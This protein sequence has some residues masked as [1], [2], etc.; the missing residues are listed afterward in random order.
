MPND[1]RVLLLAVCAGLAACSPGPEARGTAVQV[2]TSAQVADVRVVP[3]ER[4]QT[5]LGWEAVAA[6]GAIECARELPQYWQEMIHRLVVDVG[7]NRLRI[8]LPTGVEG[9]NDGFDDF[10]AKRIDHA[11]WRARRYGGVNDNDDPTVLDPSGFTWRDF[12]VAMDTV[13]MPMKRALEGRGDRLYTVLT[14]IDF[15][16]TGFDHR[17]NPPEYAELVVAGLRHLREK[18]AHLPDA[19]EVIL[20]PNNSDWSA[21]Q[22][23]GAIK[24]LGQRLASEG[25]PLP[26][27]AP[28]HSNLTGSLRMFDA[29]MQDTGVRRYV[30]DFSYHRYGPHAPGDPRAIGDRARRFGVRTAMLEHIRGDHRELVED[31]T[32]AGASAWE[33]F[34]A[35][36]CQKDGGGEYVVA[37]VTQPPGRMVRLGARTRY[38]QQYFRDVRVGAVRI[39]ASASRRELRP[40][41]FQ[42]SVGRVVVV[43][44][45]GGATTLE[46]DGLP[47]GTYSFSY[48]TERTLR[49]T[50]SVRISS[51]RAQVRM[52]AAGVFTLAG[53]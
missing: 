7:V 5:M 15:V 52:P 31:L 44:Y 48:T 27:I 26:L 53:R 17:A 24:A 10:R 8:P 16:Q 32:V 3:A 51:G 36:G 4:H 28:S 30:T 19:I 35:A 39:G 47:P 18:Y 25:L 46:I 23:A 43:V 6:A 33:Q 12:D 34:A 37:D 14:V 29:I 9:A 50:D 40:V 2:E 13:V 20:E 1:F 45:T 22:V 21:D 38:L 11:T 41:A 49:A 42:D